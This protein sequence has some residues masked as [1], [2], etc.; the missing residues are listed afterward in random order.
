MAT[1]RINKRQAVK[2][3]NIIDGASQLIMEK[4]IDSASLANI[5]KAV[6]ISKGTLHYYYSSKDDIIF[7]VAEKHVDDITDYL[8]SLIEAENDAVTPERILRLLFDSHQKIETRIKLHLNLVQQAISGNEILKNRLQ[9][10]YLEWKATVIEGMTALMPDQKY[11]EA[12][13]HIIVATID[14]LNIQ[15][16]LGVEN[17]PIGDV[18]RYFTREYQQEDSGEG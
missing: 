16:M 9:K 17:I 4:G 15:S 2:R 13:A 1:P 11:P 8:F 6:G 5:A 3:R 18:A 7:D 12:L 10:K 14:G